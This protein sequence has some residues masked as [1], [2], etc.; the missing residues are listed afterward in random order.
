MIFIRTNIFFPGLNLPTTNFFQHPTYQDKVIWDPIYQS[1][2][3]EVYSKS[4]GG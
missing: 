1:R 3:Y 4:M 2:C